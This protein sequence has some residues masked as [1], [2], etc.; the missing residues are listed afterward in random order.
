MATAAIGVLLLTGASKTRSPVP[1]AADAELQSGCFQCLNIDEGHHA[2]NLSA[3]CDYGTPNC[4][5]CED[6][7][8]EPHCHGGPEPDRCADH[9][10]Q[11]G[12]TRP[13]VARVAARLKHL[14]AKAVNEL[15]VFDSKHLRW[16]DN[17]TALQVVNCKGELVAQFDLAGDSRVNE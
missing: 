11:C 9:H 2:F 13:L 10:D 3:P 1:T 8:A 4:Y 17:R 12:I 14:D 5:W 15:V 6:D 16:N 7:I